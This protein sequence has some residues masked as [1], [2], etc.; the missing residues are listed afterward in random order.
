M[1]VSAMNRRALSRLRRALVRGVTAVLVERLA[2]RVAIQLQVALEEA[3][4]RPK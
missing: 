2:G 1:S 3:R 4:R